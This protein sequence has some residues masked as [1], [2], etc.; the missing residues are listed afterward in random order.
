MDCRAALGRE[1]VGIFGQRGAA[2]R[3]EITHLQNQAA[4]QNLRGGE[5]PWSRSES[6]GPICLGRR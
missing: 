5:P 4:W 2:E 6:F 1:A 3:A